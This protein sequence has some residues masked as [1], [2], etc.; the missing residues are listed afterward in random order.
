MNRTVPGPRVVAEAMAKRSRTA[1]TTGQFF[2]NHINL[3][4]HIVLLLINSFIQTFEI[5]IMRKYC[6]ECIEWAGCILIIIIIF[7]ISK[8]Y[9]L[10]WTFFY[11]LYTIF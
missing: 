8:N 5:K 9:L 4:F 2:V 6:F 7:I 1:V 3:T 11:F 10:A